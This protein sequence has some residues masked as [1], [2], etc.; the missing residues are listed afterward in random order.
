MSGRMDIRLDVAKASWEQHSLLERTGI[1][2][3][4]RV[5]ADTDIALAVGHFIGQHAV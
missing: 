2:C 1:A 4:K 3:K 5:Q